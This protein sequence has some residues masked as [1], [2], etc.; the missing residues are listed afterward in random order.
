MRQWGDPTERVGVRKG[1]LLYGDMQ[2]GK[3]LGLGAESGQFS[4]EGPG[5]A[6]G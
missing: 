6:L 4:P 1:Q 2:L 3:M 5:R